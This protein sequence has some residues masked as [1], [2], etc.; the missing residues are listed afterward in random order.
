MGE[1]TTWFDLIPGLAGLQHYLAHFLGRTTATDQFP[2]HF[3]LAHVWGAL[4]V[5]SFLVYAGLRFRAAVMTRGHRDVSEGALVP[6]SRF[7]SRI[8]VELFLDAVMGLMEGVMGPKNARR[9]LPLIGSLALFIF[10]SNLLALIPGF[11]PPTS[12]LKTNVAL[13]LCVFIMTHTYGIKE[14][15]LKYFKHFAGPHIP[16]PWYAKPLTWL[17]AALMV[18]IEL[19]SHFARPVSLSLR[20]MGNMAADHKVVFAFFVLI[21]VL[22]PVPFLVLGCLVVIVQTLVFS[23]LS[24]VYIS[25]AVAHEEH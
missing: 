11:L 25:M 6:P 21:P 24:M 16:A 4:V 9:F 2:T 7:S 20:L 10:C 14:H 17:L 18:V 19:I 3:T 1:H 13:A 12:M 8:F 15:G 5:M 23:L 22:V